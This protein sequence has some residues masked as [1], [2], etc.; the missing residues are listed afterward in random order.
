P[1]AGG[2]EGGAAG[3]RAARPRAVAAAARPPP[4]A[5][6]RQNPKTAGARV[7]RGCAARRGHPC[8]AP[9]RPHGRGRRR[10]AVCLAVL[11]ALEEDEVPPVAVDPQIVPRETDPLEA[12]RL[13]YALRGQVVDERRRLDA[14]KPNCAEGIAGLLAARAGGEAAA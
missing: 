1:R 10:S 5:A 13:E 7:S 12:V 6:R 4:R 3:V 11:H 2:A 14:F 8:D 9:R